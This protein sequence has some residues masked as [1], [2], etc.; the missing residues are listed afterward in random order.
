MET[1][2]RSFCLDAWLDEA[3]RGDP[4]AG[5]VELAK[6]RAAR[7][8]VFREMLTQY[9]PELRD[10]LEHLAEMH[11]VETSMLYR[12]IEELFKRHLEDHPR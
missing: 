6:A 5:L 9:P 2:V 3:F 1:T 12:V 10:G 7:E 4:P 11:R 8:N